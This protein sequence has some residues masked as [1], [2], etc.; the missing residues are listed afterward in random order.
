[1]GATNFLIHHKIRYLVYDTIWRKMIHSTTYAIQHPALKPHVQYILFN[2][3]KTLGQVVTSFSN[4]NICL[5]ILNNSQLVQREDGKMMNRRSSGITSYISGMYLKPHSFKCDHT[6]DEICIDFTPLGIK[7]FLDIPQKKYIVNEDVLQEAF[8]HHVKLSFERVFKKKCLFQRGQL[9]ECLLLNQMRNK[10]LSFLKSVI[11]YFDQTSDPTVSEATK[12]LNCTERKLQ[13]TFKEHFDI[14][15]KQYLKIA[16]FRKVLK[17][18]SSGQRSQSDLTYHHGFTD[19]SHM[20]KEFRYFTGH[21]PK[22]LSKKLQSIDNKVFVL[23][24]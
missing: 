13:R 23:A 11:E 24:Q 3:S 7:Q 16:R 21:T 20:I 8:G 17:E 22:Q 18:L 14:T 2:Q 12:Y 19:Q 15:P 6:L 4:T 9:V 10:E 5:G 1:M